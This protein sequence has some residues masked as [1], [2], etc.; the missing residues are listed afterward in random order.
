ME[1]G[2]GVFKVWEASLRMMILEDM[3]GHDTGVLV[4]PEA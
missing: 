2:F 3:A 4:C 1:V